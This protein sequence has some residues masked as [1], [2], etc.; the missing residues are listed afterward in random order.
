MFVTLSMEVQT[1]SAFSNL[2]NFWV[3]INMTLDMME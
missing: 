3:L 1:V 2:D